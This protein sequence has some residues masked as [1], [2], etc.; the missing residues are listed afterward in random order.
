METSN[1]Q[2][3]KTKNTDKPKMLVHVLHHKPTEET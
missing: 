1:R 2:A 3:M